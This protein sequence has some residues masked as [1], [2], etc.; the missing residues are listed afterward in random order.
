MVRKMQVIIPFALMILATVGAKHFFARAFAERTTLHQA[1]RD[2]DVDT[3]ELL[4]STGVDV[5]SADSEGATPLFLAS[6][7]GYTD[8]VE[9]L[10]NAG[11]NVHACDIDERT[12]LFV[13]AFEGR[14]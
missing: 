2:G 9:L 10:L 6:L 7:N 4:L 14:R 3:V 13:A 12:P 11:A 8:I 1:A 5:N